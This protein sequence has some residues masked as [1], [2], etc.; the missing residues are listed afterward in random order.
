MES[1]LEIVQSGE[2]VSSRLLEEVPEETII[3]VLLVLVTLEGNELCVS[4]RLEFALSAIES[5]SFLIVASLALLGLFE[6]VVATRAQHT[7][8]MIHVNIIMC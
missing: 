7:F 1:T 8:F 2:L 6:F 3:A 5:I 4:V